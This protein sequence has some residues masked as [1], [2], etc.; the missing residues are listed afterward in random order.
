MS[1][2]NDDGLYIRYGTEEA[3]LAKGGQ[4]SG[5]G[6]TEVIE[7]SITGTD[8]ADAAA[9][10]DRVTVLPDNVQIEQI[11]ILVDTAF[12]SAGSAVLDIGVVDLD[13]TS[14]ADDD[15]LVAAVALG[16]IDAIG[17]K[18]ELIQGTS[19]HGALVGTKTTKNTFVTA[20]Y[21]TAAFTAGE[22]RVRIHV[23]AVA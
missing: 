3:A 11:D 6:P 13:E 21:D 5:T 1:W 16:A 19:G 22:A 17:D 10:V 9:I 8:L 14:N 4:Y 7:F 23:R 20:S 2:L 12:T 18:V 15:A